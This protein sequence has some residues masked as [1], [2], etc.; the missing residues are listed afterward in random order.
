MISRERSSAVTARSARGLPS[1]VFRLPSNVERRTCD[2]AYLPAHGKRQTADGRRL[3][4]VLHGDLDLV[5]LDAHHVRLDGLERGQ[6]GGGAGADVEARA[7]AWAL[8]LVAF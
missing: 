3:S 7:V 2:R 4:L 5:A 1:S 6:L 8:D